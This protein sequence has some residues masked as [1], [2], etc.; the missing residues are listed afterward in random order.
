M[1]QVQL[2]LVQ[3]FFWTPVWKLT[4]LKSSGALSFWAKI[5]EFLE[6][7]L[8]F[9]EKILE[10]LKKS[11]SFRENIEFLGSILWKI[12]IFPF[13]RLW[14]CQNLAKSRFLTTFFQVSLSCK[15]GKAPVPWVFGQNF[16]W[17]FAVLSFFR[18]EFLQFCSKKKPGLWWKWSPDSPWAKGPSPFAVKITF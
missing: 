1:L 15:F 8:E 3:A 16:P 14:K 4:G 9:L 7:I 13:F 5:L 10:F 11:L 6:K 12:S 18:L 17:V 2:C